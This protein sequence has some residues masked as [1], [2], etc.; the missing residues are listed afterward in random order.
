MQNDVSIVITNYN[1]SKY[2]ERCLRSCLNQ[3][4]KNYEI[5]IVD[6]C[7]TDDSKDI[8]NKWAKKYEKI[9]PFF[10]NENRGVSYASN[11]GIVNSFGKFIT[12]C[13]ADDFLNKDALFF[14]SRLLEDNHDFFC[15]SSDYILVDEY[16]NIIGR[17]S[18][19][20]NPISCANMYRKD[21]LIELGLYNE[22]FRY[23]EAEKLL[24]KIH[25]VGKEKYKIYYLPIP[26][27][28][29][30]KHN[31]NKTTKYEDE[32]EELKKDKPIPPPG[33]TMK[34]MSI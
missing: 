3:T 13:D 16:E 22:K 20:T 15:I 30:R 7:S 5:V 32:I 19:L 24:E 23:Y 31:N 6:D 8:I 9:K 12:R 4:Y 2:L 28:R 14:M 11:V 21:K 26:L 17:K 27:Y 1:Y 18:Q 10:L 34:E 25:I 29:Y 33:R